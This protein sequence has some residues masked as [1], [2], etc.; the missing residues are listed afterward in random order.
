MKNLITRTIT[1]VL[2]VAIL[3][4][5]IVLHPYTLLFVFT[6]I[7]ALTVWEFTTIVNCNMNLHVN[8]FITTMAGAY[9]FIA[10]WAF[11]TNIMG[12]EVFIP[13]LISLIYLLVSELYFDRPD[14]I[15]NWA[16]AFMAQ[17]YI[18]LPF[19]SFNTLCFIGTAAGV[20]YYYWYA[21]SLFI[22][23]WSNDTGAYLF[24]SRLGKHR[25]FPRISPKKS[26]EGSIGGGLTA[27][28]ASQV[29]ASFIPFAE[30]LTPLTS[31]LLWAG[32]AL[33]TVIVG[34]WGDLVES[35]LK[36]RLGIKDSG[37]ILPG[38]GGMLDRFDSAL[39]A[40][41]A[42]VVYVYTIMLNI[43]H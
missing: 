22:F 35:L 38:H 16:M 12:A 14:N 18:A 36:R 42:A 41:P 34:T 10:V 24:G 6:A 17:L 21:L 19:A 30:T 20:T 3:V 25:L 7:T 33:L 27:I 2:F 1:G 29:I 23:L 40:I 15:Q 4:A 37:N 5:S 31:H 9:L 28:A 32:L 26:W 39:L 13:Y 43:I 11:N 8:R